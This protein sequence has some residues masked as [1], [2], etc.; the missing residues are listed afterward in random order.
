MHD[1]TEILLFQFLL[2]AFEFVIIHLS[3][4]NPNI[5][6]RKFNILVLHTYKLALMILLSCK[7]FQTDHYSKTMS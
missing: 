4:I 5:N 7:K 6:G 2:F 3:V 1:N